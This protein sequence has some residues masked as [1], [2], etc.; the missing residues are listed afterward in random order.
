MEKAVSFMWHINQLSL[1]LWVATLHQLMC[2]NA[3][4]INYMLCSNLVLEYSCSK[5]YICYFL[6]VFL[7]VIVCL[8]VS[9]GIQMTITSAD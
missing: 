7:L 4:R 2:W 3:V 8:L 5:L 1:C 9:Q 6:F